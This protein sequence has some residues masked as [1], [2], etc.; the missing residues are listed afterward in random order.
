MIP[1]MLEAGFA[2]FTFNHRMRTDDF[3]LIPEA[4]LLDIAGAIAF[5]CS[6]EAAYMT[7]S[8]MVIDGGMLLTAHT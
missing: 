4:L 6:P 5:L 7:G 2:V 1:T 3:D 8:M